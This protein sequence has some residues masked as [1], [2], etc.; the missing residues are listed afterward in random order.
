MIDRLIRDIVNLIIYGGLF[1]GLCA[2]CITALSLEVTG[3]DH[4]FFLY[5]VWI[6][7]CTAALYSGHRVIG[8]QKMAH[9]RTSERFNV[10]RKYETHI[11]IYFLVWVILSGYLFFKIGSWSLMWWMLPGGFIAFGYV[12]PLLFGKKRLRDLGWGKIVMIGW[13]WA[14]LTTFIPLWYLAHEPLWIVCLLTLL[15]MMFIIAITVPFEVRDM[16]VD[17]SVGL[18]TLPEKF[19]KKGTHLIVMVL[20]LGMMLLSGIAAWHYSNPA[21]FLTI[22]FISILTYAINQY[23]P[24]TQDDYFFGGLTDGLMIIALLSYLVIHH[25]V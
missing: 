2:S 10:I 22:T 8:L 15:R 11:W 5:S 19:G 24:K 20:C 14:W 1:I 7:V 16:M 3:H 4:L 6:G 23:S 18:M 13:S 17:K 9:I 21:F 25:L 12:L